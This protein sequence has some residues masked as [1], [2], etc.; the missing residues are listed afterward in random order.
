MARILERADG[1]PED[2]NK[3]RKKWG[4]GSLFFTFLK[5]KAGYKWVKYKIIPFLLM[6]LMVKGF[7]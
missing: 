6:I 1:V 7:D 5:L 4:G 2:T 3:K